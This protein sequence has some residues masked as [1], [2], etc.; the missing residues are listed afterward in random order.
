MSTHNK[1]FGKKII[2]DGDSLCAGKAFDDT[3]DSDA[4]AGYD[5]TADIID[6]WLKTL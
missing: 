4:W 5:V 6:S 2:W 1:L 3:K